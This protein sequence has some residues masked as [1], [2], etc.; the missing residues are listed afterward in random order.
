MSESNRLITSPLGIIGVFA[1]L[2]EV[3]STTAIFGLSPELQATFLWF[4]MGFPVFLVIMFFI[5]L[6]FNSRV[7]YAPSDFKDENN[8]MNSVGR[9]EISKNILSLKSEIESA[10]EN[11]ISE[12][13]DSLSRLGG[14]EAARLRDITDK[15]MS[16]ILERAEVT[17]ARV[18]EIVAN[19]EF[20]RNPV[21]SGVAERVLDILASGESLTGIEISKRVGMR[22]ESISRML[23]R[24]REQGLVEAKRRDRMVINELTPTGK[25]VAQSLGG[26][27]HPQSGA[28]RSE[29]WAS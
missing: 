26:R 24:L 1:G 2:A 16:S 14:E 7:L 8:Y 23:N 25:I 13:R 27:S 10:R 18:E 17:E 11:I 6:N 21:I 12:A 20:D 9:S 19:P 29:V 28:I 15:H 22:P 4:V 3:A 5:T